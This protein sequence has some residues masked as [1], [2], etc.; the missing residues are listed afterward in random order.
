MIMIKIAIHALS[1]IH[2]NFSLLNHAQQEKWN[3]NISNNQ[4]MDW[5]FFYYLKKLILNKV[6]QRKKNWSLTA[7]P[8]TFK[9]LSQIY[10]IFIF[11]FLPFTILV[12][13]WSSLPTSS[14]IVAWLALSTNSLSD[15]RRLSRLFLA[16]SSSEVS[17]RIDFFGCTLFVSFSGHIVDSWFF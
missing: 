4:F 3:K 13:Y 16:W 8:I 2:R 11:F 17:K 7:F 5:K 1:H 15:T 10:P 6:F 9:H 12:P 14:D